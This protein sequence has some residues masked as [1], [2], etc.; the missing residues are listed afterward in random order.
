MLHVVRYTL[1]T[2]LALS[3]S[4]GLVELAED[5]VHLALDGQ[6]DHAEGEDA[7]PEHG[8][9]P[10]SH[11]CGCCVAIALGSAVETLPHVPRPTL[12]WG[13]FSPCPASTGPLGFVAQLERPPRA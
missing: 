1:V 2:V 8:C 6:T 12:S 11:R 5:G 9:A 7:C 3:M 4:P 10:T 13:Q